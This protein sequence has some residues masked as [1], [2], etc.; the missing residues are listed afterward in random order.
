MDNFDVIKSFDINGN[1]RRCCFK[2]R[3][4]FHREQNDILG[5]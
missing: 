1:L 4:V 5:V 2:C 3:H